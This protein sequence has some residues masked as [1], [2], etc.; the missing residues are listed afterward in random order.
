MTNIEIQRKGIDALIKNLGYSG[1]I[2]FL[3][4]YDLG[5]GDYTRERHQ[6]HKSKTVKNIVKE[7]QSKSK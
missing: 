6:I 3:E 4:Q 7:I 1:M 5:S 2:R